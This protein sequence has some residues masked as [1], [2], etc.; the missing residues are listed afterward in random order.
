M[1]T[2]QLPQIAFLGL[3]LL[4]TGCADMPKDFTLAN[5]T[6]TPKVW[7]SP[8]ETPR[9]RYVGELVGEA[10]F[11]N[12]KED[13]V[14]NTAMNVLKWMAGMFSSK[15]IPVV[16]Q[17]PQSGMV[18]AEGRIYVADVSRQA[19]Y[20]FDKPGGK[21]EIWDMARKSA[22]FQAPI[23]IAQGK[24]TQG[25]PEASREILV[26][27]AELHSVFRL[28]Q[29]G[30]PVGEFG[31]DVLK[32]P[33]GLARDAR[34]GLIYVADTQ[35]HDIKVFGDDGV[36]Q[37]VIGKRGEGDGEFNFP[38]HLAFAD[39]RL[40]VTDTLNSRIQVF[41]ADG[42]MITKFGQRGLYVGNLVRP[43]GVAVDSERNI[44][45]IESQYDNL[46]VFNSEG[47]TLMALG[48]TGKEIGQLYLPSGVWIDN[49]DQVYVADMF[50]GRILVLQF[51]GGPK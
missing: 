40:Y 33:T 25:K 41:D 22:H 1:N 15:Q 35:A 38:T 9:Y 48:G 39:G 18:D 44:Y 51:L 16:L 7:P 31:G 47:R 20:V 30:E 13:T 29:K 10:N 3:V 19:V 24:F 14:S 45:V 8:P 17:R 21:L 28:D 37:R 23:G 32:R 6:Q 50:N 12:R 36:L 11:V 2:R 42:K 27:D 46:L 5:V 49:Q 4:V 34:R 26:T 43:K